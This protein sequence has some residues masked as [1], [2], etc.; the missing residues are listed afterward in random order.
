M[1]EGTHWEWRA[2]GRVSEGFLATFEKLPE[3][4]ERSPGWTD[5]KDVYLYAPGSSVNVTLIA[6]SQGGLKL[7]RPVAREGGVE[8]WSESPRE[9]YLF[10]GMDRYLLGE[11]TDLLGL[12]LRGHIRSGELAPDHI[13]SHLRAARPAAEIVT[14]HKKTQT[15]LASPGVQVELAEITG[16]TLEG[17]DPLLG[18]PLFSVCVENLEDLDGKSALVRAAVGSQ[19]RGVLASLGLGGEALLP[20]NELQAIALWKSRL[21]RMVERSHV[22]RA[23]A[24]V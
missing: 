22:P 17:P 2:F 6:G 19:V 23:L 21:P 10:K 18:M 15:R 24:S 20:L 4:P 16:V 13:L 3:V 12:R 1:A 5:H 11:L 8:L 9:T 14:V 7:K